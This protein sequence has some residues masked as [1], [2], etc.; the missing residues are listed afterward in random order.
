MVT[1]VLIPHQPLLKV[2]YKV[3]NQE[4]IQ[5]ED[6]SKSLPEQLSPVTR[7]LISL[8]GTMKKVPL[9]LPSIELSVNSHPI[10]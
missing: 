1:L 7:Y 8:V 4:C 9:K 5:I 2:K 3:D 6:R 10:C